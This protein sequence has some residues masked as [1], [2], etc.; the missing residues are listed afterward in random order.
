MSVS[1]SL[2]TTAKHNSGN[3]LGN[4]SFKA[5][6]NKDIDRSEF[7]KS[8]SHLLKRRSLHLSRNQHLSYDS[9]HSYYN[10]SAFSPPNRSAISSSFRERGESKQKAPGTKSCVLIQPRKSKRKKLHL[11][12]SDSIRSSRFLRGKGAGEGEEEEGEKRRRA[13]LTKLGEDEESGASYFSSLKE[14]EEIYAVQDASNCDKDTS[15]SANKDA[16]EHASKGGE[17]YEFPF[18][19][20]ERA[21]RVDEAEMASGGEMEEGRGEMKKKKNCCQGLC[22]KLVSS[23]AH[24]FRCL[25]NSFR[26]LAG[27][28]FAGIVFLIILYQRDVEF[29]WPGET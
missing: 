2:S 11:L 28:L 13:D 1:S 6:S 15:K 18:A 16:P 17:L 10:S 5:S 14:E 21:K 20:W 25:K 19:D 8:E 3:D 22:G 23:Q 9:G 26:L 29:R 7:G 24:E 27:I 12:S 4:P